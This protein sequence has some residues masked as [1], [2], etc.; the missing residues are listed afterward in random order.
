MRAER[1]ESARGEEERP[2]RGGVLE[3]QARH[4]D[5]EAIYTCFGLEAG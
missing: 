1:E 2:E 3:N 4:V 5:A